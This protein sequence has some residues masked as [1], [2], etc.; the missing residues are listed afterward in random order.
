MSNLEILVNIGTA[1]VLALRK[2]K[3]AEGKPFMINSDELPAEQSYL[4]SP[5]GSIQVVV[6]APNQRSF[7]TIR[8][9][10]VA[11]AQTVRIQH[12]LPL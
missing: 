1:A 5:D 8:Q 12:N 4:E 6:I 7:V 9:L 2:E 10:S 3:L 11:E